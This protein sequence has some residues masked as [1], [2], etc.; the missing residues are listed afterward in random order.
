MRNACPTLGTPAEVQLVQTTA[1]TIR[2]TTFPC[3][4]ERQG[5]VVVL[6]VGAVVWTSCTS[7]GVPNVGHAFRIR[8]PSLPCVLHLE[9]NVVHRLVAEAAV[10]A[11]RGG[12]I[13]ATHGLP[14]GVV[15][16]TGHKLSGCPNKV[17]RT[18]HICVGIGRQPVTT[19]Q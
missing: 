15:G 3:R 18:V 17:A 6:I 10:G 12:G 4:K 2:T 1:P 19:N 9:R 16:I 13:R 11:G 8:F 5:N 14:R 7:A